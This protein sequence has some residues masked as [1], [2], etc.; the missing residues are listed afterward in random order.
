[1]TWLSTTRTTMSIAASSRPWAVRRRRRRPARRP[2]PWPARA[3][4]R[5]AWSAA[6]AAR[7]RRRGSRETTACSSRLSWAC[8]STARIAASIA[9]TRS[10]G[11]SSNASVTTAEEALELG[12]DH[13]LGQR[14]LGADLVVDRLPAHPDPL[15]EPRHRHRGPALSVVSS[16][17]AATIRPRGVSTADRRRALPSEPVATMLGEGDST[18]PLLTACFEDLVVEPSTPGSVV[19]SATPVC[20]L[21]RAGWPRPALGVPG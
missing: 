6:A 19:Q 10:S 8:S 20:R 13:R 21:A 7:C 1:M 2:P 15:G 5:S 14:A 12:H 3:A 16:A 18:R 17:A 11:W 4:A 9:P